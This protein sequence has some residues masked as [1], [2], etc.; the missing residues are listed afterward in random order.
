MN[1]VAEIYSLRGAIRNNSVTRQ[2]MD[3]KYEYHRLVANQAL[4]D[5][6]HNRL[7]LPVNIDQFI[8]EHEVGTMRSAFA[9]HFGCVPDGLEISG[10]NPHSALN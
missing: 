5:L 3:E 4:I 7:D 8:S 1:R 10:N 9:S 6:R 2:Q